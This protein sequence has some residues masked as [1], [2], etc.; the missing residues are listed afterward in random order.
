MNANFDLGRTWGTTSAS[1][2]TPAVDSKR[3]RFDSA[4]ATTGMDGE[5]HRRGSKLNIS[6]RVGIVFSF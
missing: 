2:T 1:M 3:N 4:L 5:S 6:N